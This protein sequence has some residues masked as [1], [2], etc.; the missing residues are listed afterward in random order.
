MK[1]DLKAE[2]H[3]I[4]QRCFQHLTNVGS[5]SGGMNWTLGF[6]DPHGY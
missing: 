3:V 1:V 5:E 4:F 2:F 6:F